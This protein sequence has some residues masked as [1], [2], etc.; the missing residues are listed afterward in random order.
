MAPSKRIPA[1]LGIAVFLS[2]LHAYAAF[3]RPKLDAL[4]ESFW[5]WRATEQPFT[6]DDIP[7][8]E[9]AA[10][11][12]VDWSPAAVRK[13]HTQI[14]QFEKQWRALESWDCYKSNPKSNFL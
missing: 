8:I 6:N 7:R 2:C 12:T 11:F 9:R 1:L 3:E 14:A 5:T 10:D 13:Y 4:S